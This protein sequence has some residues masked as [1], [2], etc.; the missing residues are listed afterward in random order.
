M[1][2]SSWA[3]GESPSRVTE[4]EATR[5]AQQAVEPPAARA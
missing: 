3:D 5:L 4:A 2:E 1:T